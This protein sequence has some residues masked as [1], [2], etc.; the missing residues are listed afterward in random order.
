MNFNQGV[1]GMNV[2]QYMFAFY[3]EEDGTRHRV[4][5]TTTIE[6]VPETIPVPDGEAEQVKLRSGHKNKWQTPQVGDRIFVEGDGELVLETVDREANDKY[7]RRTYE[8]F[9]LNKDGTEIEE[10][11]EE[12]AA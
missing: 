9:G 10:P 4:W 1:S 2:S 12:E 11:E 5:N 3:E 7:M 8:A 6:E